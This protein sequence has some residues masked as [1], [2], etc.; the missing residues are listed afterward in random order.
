VADLILFVKRG[1]WGAL[2]VEMKTK[3]GSQSAEQKAWQKAVE[4][5]GYLYKVC[6]NIDEFIATI[7]EYL[8]KK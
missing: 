3:K 8:S 5:E 4:T 1:E 6:R 7:S 2:C